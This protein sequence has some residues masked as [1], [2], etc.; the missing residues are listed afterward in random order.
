M[1]GATPNFAF[2]YPA[3][4]DPTNVPGDIQNAVTSIDAW[5]K[6]NAARFLMGTAAARPAASGALT[7]T[8]YL[9]TDTGVF[10]FCTATP[11]WVA[12]PDLSTY[13]SAAAA[14]ATYMPKAGG[15]FTGSVGFGFNQLQDVLFRNR[16]D[17]ITTVAASGAARTLDPATSPEWDVTLD[18]DCTFTFNGADG[19]S[20]I[21]LLRQPA[22]VKN[23]IWP[24]TVDW[25]GASAPV[26][27][28]STAVMYRFHR[29]A[30]RWAGFAQQVV[31]KTQSVVKNTD[32]SVTSSI[33]LQDDD[34]LFLPLAVNTDYLFEA[35]IY[36]TKNASGSGDI[37]VA[38]VVPAGAAL[39]WA[40]IN[41]P[42]PSGGSAPKASVVVLASGTAI[43]FT[44]TSTPGWIKI[45]GSV[46]NGAAA[47]N[48]QMR[49]A[50]NTSNAT[51]TVVKAGSFLTTI[52]E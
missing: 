32:E 15:L 6:A 1:P 31:T 37:Q 8:I 39:Q 11:A 42:D 35:W 50:Q 23:V 52:R 41:S 28:A 33:V 5:L 46:K 2:P 7:G 18:Q 16:R 21:L 17:L 43:A 24:A 51:A 44:Q 13:L 20:I 30:G 45:F 4:L 14:A 25:P 49:W 27:Q 38:F 34:E 3:A 40:G 19:D 22:A 12:L 10:S 36:L 29:F 47:G 48:L 26:Q 9:A